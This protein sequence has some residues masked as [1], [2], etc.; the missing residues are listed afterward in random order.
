MLQMTKI[1]PSFK[2]LIALS[3]A[4][5]ATLA[6]AQDAP[7]M[8][9][10]STGSEVA[11][12]TVSPEQKTRKTPIVFLHGGPGM[13][14]TP[15]NLKKG[16][17]FRAVGF[18]TIYFDQAGGGKSKRLPAAN[19]TIDRV[20]ADV[21]ALRVK[22]GHDRIVVWG[23]SYGAAIATLYAAR[24]PNNVSGI[25][26]TSPGSY[27][28]TSS[29]RSYKGTN[30]D[31]VK[32]SKELLKAL[33]KIDSKGASAEGEISQEQAGQLFDDVVNADMMGAM[34]CK[35]SSVVPPAPG[36]GANLY[37]NRLHSKNLDKIAFKPTSFPKVPALIIRGSCDFLP[38]SNAASFAQLLGTSIVTI[39]SS[40]HGLIE[41]PA[42][43]EAAF[44]NFARGPLTAV[45]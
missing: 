6:N 4:I 34:V 33:G 28:G 3:F 13:Y 29:S 32:Y 23:S 42:A 20:I 22:L 21:D 26:L 10:L 11:V 12:W 1:S 8:T 35:G 40:G 24:H 39:A 37:A 2:G 43:V 18:T 38:E 31:K 9:P 25:I 44:T 14:T 5:T 45:E 15:G 36:T 30:R 19:Y 17:P 16:A 27:P 7:V 41:N